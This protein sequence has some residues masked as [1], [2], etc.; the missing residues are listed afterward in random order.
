VIL[1]SFKKNIEGKRNFVPGCRRNTSDLVSENSDV[2]LA[3]FEIVELELL[4]ALHINAFDANPLAVN[5][6][7]DVKFRVRVAACQRSDADDTHF[8]RWLDLN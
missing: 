8:V 3:I 5:I 7:D 2:I 4:L 1:R 6:L